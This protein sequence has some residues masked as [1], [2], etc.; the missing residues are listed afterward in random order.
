MPG[1][2][3]RCTAITIDDPVVIEHHC[4]AHRAVTTGCVD[5]NIP[6]ALVQRGIADTATTP[7]RLQVG[8]TDWARITGLGSGGMVSDHPL[9]VGRHVDRPDGA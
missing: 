2:T 7:E 3:H 1:N 9:E 8:T 4:Y 5:A 6:R